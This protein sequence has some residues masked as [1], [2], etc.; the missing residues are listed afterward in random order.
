MNVEDC[1]AIQAW[2]L[3]VIRNE[4]T[5]ADIDDCLTLLGQLDRSEKRELW[6]WL[7]TNDPNLKTWL[8]F[9]GNPRE[10]A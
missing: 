8:K 7:A 3:T 5:Q 6:R 2:L 4:P 10:A 1:R 9:Q